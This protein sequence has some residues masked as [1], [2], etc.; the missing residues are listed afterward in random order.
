MCCY[1]WGATHTV[2]YVDSLAYKGGEKEYVDVKKKA[3]IKKR[4]FEMMNLEMPK[5]NNTPEKKVEDLEKVWHGNHINKV[6]KAH[7]E[8]TAGSIEICKICPFKETYKW[9]K[10]N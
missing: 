1:D 8:G 2:G 4:G 7:I 10:I 9:K 5:K 3:D 6:R